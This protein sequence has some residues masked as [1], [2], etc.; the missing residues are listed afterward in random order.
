VSDLSH[1][2][3]TH[4]VAYLT[5]PPTGGRHWPPSA[6]GA[7]G[8]Q[9]CAIYSEPVVDEFAVHSL[10]HGAVW[11]TYQPG[12]PAS[13]VAA[14]QLLAGIRPDH[15]LVSPY[16][17]GKSPVT[18]TAWGAQL[19]VTDP[20]DPRLVEFVRQYAGGAQGGEP[21]ADCAHGSTVVQAQAAMAKASS[22]GA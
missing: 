13:S 8:W 10:E 11:V 12:V 21:G 2:H 17:G 5:H 16:P 18:I 4:P 19:A 14:L 22:T 1:D 9:A 3:V 6:F 20:H 15:V 7:Y